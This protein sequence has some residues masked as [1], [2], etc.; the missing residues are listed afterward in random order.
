MHT[1]SKLLVTL[2]AGAFLSLPAVSA[3]ATPTKAGAVATVNGT[4]IPQSTFDTFYAEQK[5]QGAPDSAELR[6]AVREELIRREVLLQEAKKSGLHKTPAVA[7]QMEMARQAVLIRAY[8]QDYVR[9]HPISDAQL[10]AEYEAVKTKMGGTEYKSRHILV[11]TEDQ[12][13]AI[14]D[15]LK[16]GAKFDELAKQSK[17]PGSKEN[18]G[19]LGWSAAGSYVPPFAEALKKLEKG[20][21][22][23][24]PVKTDFGW[25]VI[26]LEDTRPLEAPAFEAIKPQLSQRANQQQVEKMIE[27]LRTKAKVQ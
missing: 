25:H 24:A 13:K 1:P 27:G 21:Y 23:E 26:Q 4:A 14:V 20:K 12:A 8:I 7:S 9:K 10:K 17:D 6:S 18:G 16:K 19:D 3:D 2:L 15:N 11:E 5:G 22:T